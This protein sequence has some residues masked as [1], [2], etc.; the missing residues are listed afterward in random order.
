MS[1]NNSFIYGDFNITTS[2]S[3]GCIYIRL[4][5]N[6]TYQCYEDNIEC[7]DIES[8]FYHEETYNIICECFQKKPNFEANFEVD[9]NRLKIIFTILINGSY[10]LKFNI[11]VK[12]KILNGDTQISLNI[13]RLEAKYKEDIKRLETKHDEDIKQLNERLI[14]LECI[15]NKNICCT[16][17]AFGNLSY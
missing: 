3:D 9:I 5:N 15:I 13:T 8:P 1:L 12:E 16:D 7:S 17:R 14:K 2:F 11:I 10:S 6:I 4:V